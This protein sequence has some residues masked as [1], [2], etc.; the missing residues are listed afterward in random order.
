VS[1]NPKGIHRTNTA[2][3]SQSTG[4]GTGGEYIG[5]SKYPLYS[6]TGWKNTMKIE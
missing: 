3:E 6:A 1:R 2:G 4:L 5:E